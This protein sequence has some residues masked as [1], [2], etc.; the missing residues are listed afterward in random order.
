MLL[1]QVPIVQGI[2][3][4]GDGGKPVVTNPQS[5]VGQSF[6]KVAENVARQVAIRNE[7]FAPT[8]V[9]EVVG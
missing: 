7:Q 4:G 2:R 1:G 8:K 9:V 3:E 6:R 5:P